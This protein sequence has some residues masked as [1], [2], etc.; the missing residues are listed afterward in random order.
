MGDDCHATD[1]QS[2]NSDHGLMPDTVNTEHHQPDMQWI[3]N[4]CH[5]YASQA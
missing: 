5:T 3:P 1:H 2:R 4:L